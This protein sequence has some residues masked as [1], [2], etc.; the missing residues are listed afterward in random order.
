MLSRLLGSYG[1]AEG[2]R[3]GNAFM[4]YQIENREV[5]SILEVWLAE[6]RSRHLRVAL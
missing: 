5:Y 4:G 6:I 1:A 2:Q 3:L